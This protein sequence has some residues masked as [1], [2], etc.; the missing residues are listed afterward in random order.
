VDTLRAFDF[1]P[2]D[3]IIEQ[4][5]RDQVFSG[6]QLAVGDAGE[7]RYVHSYGRTQRVPTPGDPIGP[8]TRFDVASLTKIVATTAV[9]LRLVEA[10]RLDLDAPVLPLLPELRGDDAAARAGK[11]T[12]SARHLLE[13]SGGLHWWKPFYEQLDAAAAPGEAPRDTLA[14]LA[15]AVPLDAPP[16]TRSVYTDLGFILLATLC[17]RLGGA[18]IDELAARAVWTPLGMAATTFVDLLPRA[19]RSWSAVATEICPRRGLVVGEVHD[20]NA[21]AAG[22]VVGHAG[23]FSTAEDL[24]RFAAVY[25]R[26]WNG[27]RFPGSFPPE[28]ARAFALPAPVPGSTRS[29]GWDRPSEGAG[30]SQ[31]GDRW[32]RVDAVGH[33]G[34]TGA[35]MWLDLPRARWLVLLTNRVHPSRSD[36]RIK[37]VRPRVYD[38]ALAALDAA[39]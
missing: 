35:S 29:L 15:A 28:L 12:L 19:P 7:S 10:G 38:A 14:R 33:G 22:G 21:H 13:H 25:A 4:A 31:A 32:P 27:E 6:A 23:V 30:A 1:G 9:A 8:D 17:E 39:P 3:A 11:D 37:Q 36:E 16:R 26:S 5:I 2:V 34:F 24:G 18:R 20:D